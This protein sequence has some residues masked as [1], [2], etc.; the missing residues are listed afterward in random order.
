MNAYESIPQLAELAS[1]LVNAGRTVGLHGE[2]ADAIAD[3][4]RKNNPDARI[5]DA[6]ELALSKHPSEGFRIE[7]AIIVRPNRNSLV[8]IAENC[9]IPVLDRITHLYS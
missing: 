1:A 8:K 7:S 4:V 2:R 5:I 3:A 9:R 6:E